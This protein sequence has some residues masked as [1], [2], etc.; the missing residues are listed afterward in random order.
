MLVLLTM[1]T[2]GTSAAD[3]PSREARL[4]STSI[5][6]LA[7][8]ATHSDAAVRQVVAS[9]RRA[10]P[11][12]LYLLAADQSPVVRIAVAT[13]IATDE[14]TFLRLKQDKNIEVRSVVARFEYVP[15]TAL[16][17]ITITRNIAITKIRSVSRILETSAAEYFCG[18]SSVF[19]RKNSVILWHHRDRNQ[20]ARLTAPI[21]AYS[22][23]HSAGI[24]E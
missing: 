4:P 16:R 7:E 11:D 3:D 17:K 23:K 13:N 22:A 14:R 2:Q 12:L 19:P 18:R 24:F 5:D 6:R 15:A 10:P 20:S 8:L 21:P 9:N 1:T